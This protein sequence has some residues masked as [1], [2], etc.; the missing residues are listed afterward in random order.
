MKKIVNILSVTMLA[1][2]GWACTSDMDYNAGKVGSISELYFPEDGYYLELVSGNDKSTLFSWSPALASDGYAPMYEVVFYGDA[3]GKTE[4]ARVSAGNTTSIAIPHK[5]LNKVMNLTGTLP[6]AVGKVYWTAVASRAVTESATRPAVREM[7]VKRL[8]GFKVAPEEL[9]LT[10]SATETGADI[11]AA[12]RFA[13]VGDGEIFEIF[14]RL[15]S[16]D[17]SITD[18]NT[19][20]ARRFNISGGL[21]NEDNSSP[22]SSSYDGIYRI[23]IDLSTSSATIQRFENVRWVMCIQKNAQRPLAYQGG[24]VWSGTGLKTNFESGW[25]DDRYFFRAELDGT[26][27]KLGGNKSDFG[28]APSNKASLSWDVYFTEEGNADWD[29][30]YKVIP[31]YHGSVD[32]SVNV[33]LNLNDSAAR[34]NH[35][36]EFPDFE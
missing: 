16:G 11:T 33:T 35:T 25:K 18:G 9:Y 7:D 23:R 8:K 10:G 13:D 20:D 1:A 36:I 2:F 6:E 29:Y 32:L 19:A 12:R 34:Y 15:G 21:I 31:F 22:V 28:G 24:G 14:T 17:F 4:I 5:T 26:T 27:I 3:S 30:S